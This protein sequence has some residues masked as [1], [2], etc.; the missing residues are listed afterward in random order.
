[1]GRPTSRKGGTPS[2]GQRSADVA[3]CGAPAEP[4][5]VGWGF[6]TLYALAYT[7]T[8]LLFLA[9]LL[10]SLALKVNDLVGIGAAPSRLALVTSVGSLLAM[11]ANPFF[12]RL[13]DRTSSAWG[14][15]RPWMLVGL[16]TGSLGILAVALAPNVAVVLVGWCI[17]QVFFNALLA[18]MAAVMPDHVPTDQRGMVSG[19]IAICLPVASVLGTFLVQ[20]FDQNVL[21]MLMVPCAVGASL[22]LLFVARLTDRRLEPGHRPPWSIREL[23]STFYVNP[24]RNPDFAWVFA[25]R[26]LLVTAYAFLVTYQAYYLLEH[27]GTSEADVPHQ[28]Y[29][30]TLIQS[31]ALVASALVTGKLSDHTGRRKA[32]VCGAA[33]VYGTAL[34]VIAGADDL[35]TY[36]VG[37]GLGGVGFGMYMAVDLALVVDV[38][39]D[40]HQAAKDLGVLNIAGALPF[41]L[42]PA[43]APAILAVGG[44]SYRTLFGVAGACAVAGAAS[45]FPVKG[46]R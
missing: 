31:A 33:L 2:A 24:R 39:P 13:S 29:L 32:F 36:L 6:I 43:I 37:M 35:T 20:L 18:A 45:I 38:L 27:L 8:S 40:T 25:S 17:A 46:V 34:L 11:I 26:F 9:P 44:D 15:R 3:L 4:A 14:M 19:I 7:G 42:A 28:I 21:T 23:L 10:V 16:T 22:V 30:G 41:S 1:M 12:G 5:R